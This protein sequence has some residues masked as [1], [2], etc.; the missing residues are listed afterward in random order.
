MG[1]WSFELNLKSQKKTKQKKTNCEASASLWEWFLCSRHHLKHLDRLG[2]RAEQHPDEIKQITCGTNCVG[3]GAAVS[4]M[5]ALFVRMIDKAL[6][7][8]EC[9]V[10]KKNHF[11]TQNTERTVAKKS[12][13]SAPGFPCHR[14]LSV[15]QMCIRTGKTTD[16]IPVGA[17]K[18]QMLTVKRC[19]Y[20][21]WTPKDMFW[22]ERLK[23]VQ[24]KAQ[25]V[26]F[27]ILK[28]ILFKKATLVEKKWRDLKGMNAAVRQASTKLTAET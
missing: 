24:R 25:A 6:Q 20:S 3:S 9:E 28:V 5:Q 12:S 19:P 26:T 22:S 7:R 13:Q 1:K 14:C 27:C 21:N 23:W 10:R 11:Q 4:Q 8:Q 15:G 17:F 2:E 16:E 18:G